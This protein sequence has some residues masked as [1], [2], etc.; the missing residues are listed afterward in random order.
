VSETR[1]AAVAQLIAA[2]KRES[3]AK[4]ASVRK[5]AAKLI[6]GPELLTVSSVAR[7]AGV[8]RW[9]IYNN[10]ELKTAVSR[11]AAQQRA[12]WAQDTS[13]KG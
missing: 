1:Q 5:A 3:K 13:K 12:A 10:P 4:Q 2:K 11:A 6:K 7:A 8:S 9:L